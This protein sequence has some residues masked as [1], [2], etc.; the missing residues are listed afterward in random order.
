MRQSRTRKIDLASK[1]GRDEKEVRRL[2]D[3]D[4]ASSIARINEALRILGKELVVGI[5]DYR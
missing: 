1:L 4:H 2:L 3:I 5:V